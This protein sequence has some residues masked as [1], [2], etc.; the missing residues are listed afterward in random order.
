MLP[1]LP[2]LPAQP[3]QREGLTWPDRS[4]PKSPA[5][6]RN[7]S[8]IIPARPRFYGQSVANTAP[9]SS[10]YAGDSLDWTAT[11]ALYPA[12]TYAVRCVFQRVGE[13]PVTVDA[14][15]SGTDHAFTLSAGDSAGMS[16]GV[17]LWA[18]R[19]TALAGSESAIAAKGSI[20][21]KPDPAGEAPEPTHAERCLALVKAALENRLTDVQESFSILGQDITKTP[22]EQLDRMR[23]RYQK[24]VN[25][26][27]RKLYSLQTGGRRRRSRIYL[28]D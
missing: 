11:L 8:G 9:L 5:P 16:P 25:E 12:G 7:P 3:Q 1:A 19:A 27:R 10:I 4:N 26:E 28:A 2:A 24:L 14:T 20:T 22:A 21:I 6:D 23:D 15:N 13:S 17:W 18:Y